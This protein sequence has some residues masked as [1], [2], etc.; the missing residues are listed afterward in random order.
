[1]VKP[2]PNNCCL[3]QPF[4]RKVAKLLPCKHFSLRWRLHTTKWR[5]VAHNL[6]E[7]WH[8]FVLE[9]LENLFLQF[10]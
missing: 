10:S 8:G 9:G 5:T 2:V 3:I 4:A 7:I 1:M 6:N